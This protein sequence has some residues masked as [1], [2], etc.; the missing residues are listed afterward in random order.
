MFK[1]IIGFAIRFKYV[2]KKASSKGEIEITYYYIFLCLKIVL[3]P[4]S[5]SKCEKDL[6][7]PEVD[8]RRI[9]YSLNTKSDSPIYELWRNSYCLTHKIIKPVN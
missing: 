4:M 7:I 8:S 6:G 9:N 5:K 2:K 3:Q 1:Q